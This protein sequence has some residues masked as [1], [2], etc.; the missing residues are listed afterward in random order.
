MQTGYPVLEIREVVNMKYTQCLL[1]NEID[2]MKYT[3][4]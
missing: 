3:Q 1:I 2:T 4:C